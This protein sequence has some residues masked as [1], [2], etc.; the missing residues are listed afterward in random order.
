MPLMKLLDRAAFFAAE[1]SKFEDVPV[2]Q[3]GGMV[4]IRVLSGEARD[5]FN[6]YIKSFGD[7]PRQAS[8][9]NAALLVQ[10]CIEESGEPMFT[11]E[12]IDAIR[13]KSV[14]ALDVMAAAAMRI[15]GMGVEAVPE[16][17]KNSESDQSDDSGSDSH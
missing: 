7:E 13:K 17:E 2:P 4:R 10:T 3:L 12:D 8:A 6:A 9:I 11:L 14:G 5:A 1:D 15:N 16:A